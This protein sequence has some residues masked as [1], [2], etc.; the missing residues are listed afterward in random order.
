M[1]T[2]KNNWKSL[3][4]NFIENNRFK[5]FKWGSWDC[6]KFSNAVIKEMTG[7]DLIPKELKWKNE[8]EAIE[9][10][11]NYG[12]TMS[13]SI[14]KACKAKGVTQVNKAYMQKGDLIVYKEQEVLVGVTDGSKV[15]TPS[16]DMVVAK[17]DVNILSVWRVSN[18]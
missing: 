8:K 3:F 16:D 14:A 13:K 15:L 12:G 11:K 6:C 4:D 17:Q 7:E 5:P 18:V 10:I 9:S 2:K 1:L